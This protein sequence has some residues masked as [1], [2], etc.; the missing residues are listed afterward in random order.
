MALRQVSQYKFDNGDITTLY[1]DSI[2]GRIITK[3][4]NNKGEDINKRNIPGGVGL[5]R[6]SGIGIDTPVLDLSVK[7][8]N[9]ENVSPDLRG[10]T[11]S[12][13]MIPSDWERIDSYS[14]TGDKGDVTRNVYKRQRNLQTD[15]RGLPKYEMADYYI[16]TDKTGK[17][18]DEGWAQ[19][20]IK[21]PDEEIYVDQDTGQKIPKQFYNSIKHT[22]EEIPQ[23][24]SDK[25]KG[26]IRIKKRGS[27]QRGAKT[28]DSKQQGRKFE[29]FKL[30]EVLGLPKEYINLAAQMAKG[31]RGDYKAKGPKH[32]DFFSRLISRMAE[33]AT[34]EGINELEKD[35]SSQE[36]MTDFVTKIVPALE[37]FTGSKLT[38]MNKKQAEEMKEK[39][40]EIKRKVEEITKRGYS[41][42][43]GNPEIDKLY[44]DYEDLRKQYAENVGTSFSPT[45]ADVFS[46]LDIRRAEGMEPL[47]LERR[48]AEAEAR[49][50]QKLSEKAIDQANRIQIIKLRDSL[51]T[52]GSLGQVNSI[53]DALYKFLGDVSEKKK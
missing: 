2:N 27:K 33:G 47:L 36:A 45:S 13:G 15:P 24:D 17:I 21:K 14:Y 20:D 32:A 46:M 18:I 42:S 49:F 3:T 4:V 30:G 50:N 51:K 1:Q 29:D 53:E 31:K 41:S 10:Q 16:E 37:K 34:E 35:R 9:K 44:K 52:A 43:E 38:G 28:D 6:A 25:A 8:E 22:Y 5:S 40:E 48:K 39:G 19:E 23:L 7:N 26:E 12:I 11:A